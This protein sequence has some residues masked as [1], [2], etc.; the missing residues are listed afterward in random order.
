MKKLLTAIK[1]FLSVILFVVPIA[2]GAGLLF[3]AAANRG[4]PEKLPEQE[5]PR[6]LRVI[7]VQPT[8]VI[9]RA[10]GFGES[11]ASNSFQAIAEVKGKIVELHP[12]LKSGSFIREGE[13]LVAIDTSDIEISIQKLQ[14][15]IARSEASVQEL[16][17]TQKNLESGL[18]IEQ[19]SLM[20]AKRELDRLEGLSKNGQAISASEVDDQRRNVLAQQQSV[21]NLQNSLN[22]LPA[23]IKSAEA[24]IA[25]SQANLVS[26]QR[27]LERC[28]IVAPFNCRLGSVDL[29]VNEVV[30]VGQQ[31][32]TALAI[33]KLEVEAQFGLDKV[34]K[35]IRPDS[36]SPRLVRDLTVDP[37]VLVRKFFDVDVT[38]RYGAGE[39][40]TSREAKFERLREQLDA[41][42]RTVGIVVSVD[43][44]F[45]QEGNA[46]ENGPPPV[47]GTYCEVEL[48][49]KPIENSF[50]VPRSAIR[51]DAVFLVDDEN[52]LR[53]HVVEVQLVQ[54]NFAV[55]S[56][57]EPGDRVV[58]SDPTPAIERM[59]VDPQLDAELIQTLKAEA[60]VAE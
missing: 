16:H 8:T 53:K 32:L 38:L 29:E 51:D 50:V 24:S 18:A 42:A 19:S 17:A 33:D 58:V 25:V 5:L 3:W 36:E 35:L 12:E 39:V 14:A 52:R 23:Q 45:Q 54:R 47:P 49:G 40:R 22:L 2:A 56:G 44:P 34:A 21:Q 15:E 20:L 4:Q 57:L 27:D 55:I 31:L 30:S 43:H 46:K 6:T 59:L 37:Q 28:R 48:R 41:Q 60:G 26:S 13:L 7:E 9:P 10:I 1:P 11:V